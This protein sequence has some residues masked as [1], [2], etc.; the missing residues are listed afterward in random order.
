M[1][2]KENNILIAIFFI[3]QIGYAIETAKPYYEARIYCNHIAKEVV[4]AQVNYDKAKSS[5]AAAKEMV[6]LAEQGLGEKNTLGEPD[7][8]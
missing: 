2:E 8:E 5:L 3:N 4:Q 1:V 7:I 6:Y